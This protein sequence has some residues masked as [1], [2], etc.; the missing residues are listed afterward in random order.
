MAMLNNH[1]QA[2]CIKYFKQLTVLITV[3]Y[4]DIDWLLAKWPVIYLKLTAYSFQSELHSQ[5]SV[6]RK[7]TAR[8]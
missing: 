6:Q 8:M 7:R 4:V 5:Q 2:N 3:S 1:N